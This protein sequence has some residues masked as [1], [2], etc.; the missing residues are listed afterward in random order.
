MFCQQH[1]MSPCH[2]P[3]VMWALR[4]RNTRISSDFVMRFLRPSV[5]KPQTE[6]MRSTKAFDAGALIRSC[7]KG[8]SRGYTGIRCSQGCNGSDAGGLLRN[9]VRYLFISDWAMSIM[10]LETAQLETP[11]T[12]NASYAFKTICTFHNISSW[13]NFRSTSSSSSRK[14]HCLA[15]LV[16]KGCIVCGCVV[17][18]RRWPMRA[19]SCSKRDLRWWRIKMFCCLV[20]LPT[21]VARDAGLH[22]DL[23][24]S[25]CI[26][27]K[28]SY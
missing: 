21:R 14:Y 26:D 23:W 17:C 9:S 2:C 28:I 8:A 11:K 4:R 3:K 19:R 10:S 6:K 13:Y 1:T 18:G 5:K 7:A 22:C 25:P 24:L 15:P 20:V 12:G 16:L 27:A